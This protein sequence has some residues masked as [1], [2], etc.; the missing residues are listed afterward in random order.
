MDFFVNHVMRVVLQF[1]R[2]MS[3]RRQLPWIEEIPRLP[4][5]HDRPLIPLPPRRPCI[6]LRGWTGRA[7]AVGLTGITRLCTAAGRTGTFRFCLR[8][9]DWNA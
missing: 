7:A 3:P 6:R 8:T 9:V 5:H 1:V 4:V 2:C